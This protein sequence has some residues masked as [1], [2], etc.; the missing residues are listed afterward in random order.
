VTS[1]TITTTTKKTKTEADQVGSG[2]TKA[3]NPKEGD[4]CNFNKFMLDKENCASM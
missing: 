4:R 2:S 3:V 1:T